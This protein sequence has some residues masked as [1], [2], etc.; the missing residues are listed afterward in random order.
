MALNKKYSQDTENLKQAYHFHQIINKRKKREENKNTGEKKE[1]F[2]E[3]VMMAIVVVALT[4]I[5]QFRLHHHHGRI[6]NVPLFCFFSFSSYFSMEGGEWHPPTDN[7]KYQ[8]L[9]HLPATT[10]S[11]EEHLVKIC[12]KPQANNILE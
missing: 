8:Q 12:L 6:Q 3:G 7:G 5:S 11:L 4:G 1:R 10:K 9:T 2:P